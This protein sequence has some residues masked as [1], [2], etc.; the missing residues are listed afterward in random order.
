[1]DDRRLGMA[2]RARRHARGWR[3]VD[4]AAAAGLGPGVCSLLER[5]Q[6]RRLSVRTA[7]AIAAALDLHLAWDIGWQRQEVDRLLDADHSALASQIAARLERLGW[8]TRAEVSFNH[9]GERGRIDLL[10]FHPR[11]RVLLVVEI[12]TLLADAQAL[13][14][15]LDVK[16]RVGPIVA[17]DIG[18]L[19][20]RVVPAIVIRDSTTV[21]RHLVQLAPLFARFATRGHAAPRWLADPVDRIHGILMLTKLP[22]GNGIDRRRAGRRR[23]RRRSVGNGG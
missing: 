18:W 6:V 8:L 12:K 4:L 14:G 23:I 7:R 15:S 9:Y 10:A 17:R 13:L 11:L 16:A 20:D 1:M 5:G 3:L 2:V 21:R 19:A 22:H